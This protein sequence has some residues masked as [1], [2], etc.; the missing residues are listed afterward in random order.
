M[1]NC[2][3]N[4]IIQQRNVVHTSLAIDLLYLL[5]QNQPEINI[6]SP[7]STIV[8]DIVHCKIGK[9]QCA[10]SQFDMAF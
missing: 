5:A 9:P 3:Q 1:S 6:L 8:S 4:H 7:I 10:G 2:P